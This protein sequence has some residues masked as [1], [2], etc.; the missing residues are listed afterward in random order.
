M[1]AVA[2]TMAGTDRWRRTRLPGTLLLALVLI[3]CSA[4]QAA[5]PTATA[6]AP[7]ASPE[8]TTDASTP[9]PTASPTPS[10][11]PTPADRSAADGW[12]EAASFGNA[13]TIESVY[14]VVEAPFGLVA[15]GVRLSTRAL[16]VFGPLPGGGRV[17]LS[18]DGVTWEDVT[19][20][21]VFE[22][23]AILQAVV[24]ADGSVLAV[25]RASIPEERTA[26]WESSDGR[27]WA[28]IA[29]PFG[30]NPQP[31]I[32][33]GDRG[34]L[35]R[36]GF[37]PDRQALYHSTDGRTFVSVT[38]PTDGRLNI[39]SAA[40]G[41]E[42][43]VLMAEADASPESPTIYASGDG[44]AWFEASAI[45]WNP[46]AVAAIGPDWVVIDAPPL[47]M[48]ADTDVRTW[49]SANGLEWA[50]AGAVTLRAHAAGGGV[51]CA[52]LPRLRS[53]GTF[54]ILS[55]A[56]SY[57]CAEGRVERFGS[58]HVTVDG[59]TWLAL[60]FVAVPDLGTDATRGT[61]ISAGLDVENGTWL[62][63]EKDYRATF[64]FRP[65]D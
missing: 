22:G 54:V 49:T 18:P 32:A 37:L 4:D 53:T 48:T 40:G 60:P 31:E 34:F 41:P 65:A 56:L 17:W 2:R 57:P 64:W 30:P 42:G 62:V 29:L 5:S 45:D 26:A 11:N 7:T 14:D 13:G 9:T 28:E 24:R 36:T 63:G 51:S 43:F 35:A 23:A 1:R 10:P 8:P 25:G 6:N 61:S 16:S 27:A 38:D 12:E 15:V 59:A 55:T 33:D 39:F 58:A 44:S 46:A 47:G 19:P 50:E 52:E 20:A 21:D 3:G